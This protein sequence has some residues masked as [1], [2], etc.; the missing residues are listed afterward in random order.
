M[1]ILKRNKSIKKYFIIRS[2]ELFSYFSLSPV[3]LGQ[4]YDKRLHHKNGKEME[5][6]FFKTGIGLFIDNGLLLFYKIEYKIC[7]D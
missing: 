1:N 5:N 7:S 6:I 2:R 3:H 4:N